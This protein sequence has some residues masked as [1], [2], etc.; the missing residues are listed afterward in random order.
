VLST[1]RFAECERAVLQ[2]EVIVEALD[3]LAA[4]R[5]LDASGAA[6]AAALSA[7]LSRGPDPADSEVGFLTAAELEARGPDAAAAAVPAAANGRRAVFAAVLPMDGLPDAGRRGRLA[8]AARRALA[9][10]APSD[11]A[12]T[13]TVKALLGRVWGVWYS[14]EEGS[15]KEAEGKAAGRKTER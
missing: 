2:A 8:A 15:R 13:A 11:P 6:F 12:A 3:A 14:E 5:W 9:A 1:T 10:A 4:D 7:E